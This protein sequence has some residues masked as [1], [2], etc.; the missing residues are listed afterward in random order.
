[1]KLAGSFAVAG[2]SHNRSR[3]NVLSF[4]MRRAGM[5]RPG[6]LKE[7]TMMRTTN[8]HIEILESRRMLA[9]AHLV[10]TSLHIGGEFAFANTIVVGNSADGLQVNVSISWTNAHGVPKSLQKSFLLEK[11]KSVIIHGGRRDD[12]ITIDQTHS[13]F[14]ERALILGFGGNDIITGGDEADRIDGGLG[15]DTINAGA[16][17]NTVRGGAGNDTIIAGADGNRIDGGVGND[18][19]TSGAGDDILVGG[20]GNDTIEAGDGNDKVFGGPGDDAMAGGIGNDTLWG[21]AGNDSIDGG[22]GDDTLGGVAGRNTLLGGAGSDTF[23]VRSLA[24]NPTNDFDVLS[25]VLKIARFE[26]GSP[27]I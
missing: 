13:V 8:S 14:A 7:T 9:V 16:G 18:S 5:G 15:N 23:I 17:L 27:G 10:G 26:A 24:G 2:R 21:G 25:D 11:I 19:I 6:K 22:V 4:M 3:R 12:T 1:M 20:L